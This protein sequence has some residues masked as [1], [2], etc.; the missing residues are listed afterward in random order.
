MADQQKKSGGSKKIGR[1]RE[2]CARYRGLH[3]REKHKVKR[4]LCSSGAEAAKQYAE[5]HNLL[6]Y[7][8]SLTAQV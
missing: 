7:L 2:K 4:V 3:I 1:N 8:G 6:G 5:K